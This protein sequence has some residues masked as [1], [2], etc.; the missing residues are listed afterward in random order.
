MTRE[1]EIK[2]TANESLCDENRIAKYLYEKKGYPVDMNGNIPS[3]NETM[4]DAEKYLKYNK[5][6]FI[7]KACIWLIDRSERFVINTP[8]YY[9]YDYKQAVED[10]KNYM[11]EE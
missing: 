5:N 6:Q 11:K 2:Q 9:Y 7:D 3:F 10:F 8:A 4:K 1:E